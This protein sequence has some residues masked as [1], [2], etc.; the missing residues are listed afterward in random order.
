MDETPAQPPAPRPPQRHPG[1]ARVGDTAPAAGPVP[2]AVV[3][4]AAPAAARS[5]TAAVGGGVLTASRATAL[6][7][8]ALLGPSLLLLPGLAARQAGA[9]AVLAWG[10]LLALSA[11]L[12]FVFSR[13]GTAFGSRAGVAGY[14]AAGLGPAAGRTAGWAFCLGVITGAPV[15]CLIGGQYLAAAVGR[16][17]SGAAFAGALLALVLLLRLAG[18]TS[19]ARVQLPLVGLLLALLVTAVA[20]SAH[21]AAAAHWHPFLGHGWGGVAGAAGHLMLA[22]VGWEAAA[23]L[24]ARLDDAPRR[25]PRVIAAAFV[26]TSAVYLSL[27]VALQA[28]LGPGAATNTPLAALLAAG[29]GPAGPWLTAGTALLLTLGVTNAYLAGAAATAEHLLRPPGRGAARGSPGPLLTVGAAA[30]GAVLLGLSALRLMDV[31]LLVALPTAF[32]LLVYLVSCASATRLLRGPARWAAA[33][34]ALATLALLAADG[35]V[36]AAALAAALAA[37]SARRPPGR[38]ATRSRRAGGSCRGRTH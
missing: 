10:V 17:G 3:T 19:G 30:F 5:G 26:I 2:G 25:L 36:A 6:Y 23:P 15:V 28:V 32:F 35:P 24:T 37:G 1:T 12:A 31:S 21:R 14:A 18:A 11:L 16:P 20:A 8:G 22:F 33:A 9:A 7:V 38:G 34:A 13:L 29:V 4:R 27:A